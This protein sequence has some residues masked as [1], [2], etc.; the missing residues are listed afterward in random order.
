MKRPVLLAPDSAPDAFPPVSEALEDPPGLLAIGGDLSLPRLLAAYRRGVFPWYSAG[1]PILWWAPD[2]RMVLFPAEL[3]LRRSLVKRLRNG[4]FV[5]R[6]DTAFAAVLEGCAAPRRDGPGTWLDPDMRTAYLA[7]HAAG[8]AH[9]VEAW[10]YGE[11]VGGLYGVALGGVFFGESMFSR[12][13]DAS[14][15]A[16]VA[17]ARWWQRQGGAVIDCQ[18][19]NPHLASLGARLIAR[20]EF[21]R[22]LADHRDAPAPDWAGFPTRSADLLP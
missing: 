12:E 11:L 10:R 17:L 9:S 1:Q 2:P 14:K 19:P 15:V 20:A 22:L 16:L 18:L 21:D 13:T 6:V 8:L 4:A 3:R 7:L 5:L